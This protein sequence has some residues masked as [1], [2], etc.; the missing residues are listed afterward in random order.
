MIPRLKVMKGTC[1]VR[2]SRCL[3]IVPPH[4]V[5]PEAHDE[6][7]AATLNPEKLLGK[8]VADPSNYRREGYH[9]LGINEACVSVDERRIHQSR[10]VPEGITFPAFRQVEGY[11]FL[12]PKEENRIGLPFIPDT[13]KARGILDGEDGYVTFSSASDTW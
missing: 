3:R 13:K 12:P 9:S 4:M 7:Q 10:C 1:S 2:L 8:R 6:M 11:T 5:L